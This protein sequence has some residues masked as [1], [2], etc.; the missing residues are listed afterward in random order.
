[1][2]T[3]MLNYNNNQKISNSYLIGYY[4][5][6]IFY[7]YINNDYINTNRSVIKDF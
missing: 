6:K 4:Y 3:Q 7:F 5:N 1:M 2:K